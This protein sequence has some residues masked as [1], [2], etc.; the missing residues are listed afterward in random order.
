MGLD[1]PTRETQNLEAIDEEARNLRVLATTVGRLGEAFNNQQVPRFTT[2][3][4]VSS[5]FLFPLFVQCPGIDCSVSLEAFPQPLSNSISP[6]E[7]KGGV[8]F[9]VN[10]TVHCICIC[11]GMK[12]LRVWFLYQLEGIPSCARRFQGS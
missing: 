3:Y 2:H 9:G 5:C 8:V 1:S 11:T 6:K 12:E 10:Y 7:R 4:I